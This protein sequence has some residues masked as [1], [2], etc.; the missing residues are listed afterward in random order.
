MEPSTSS[1]LRCRLSLSF[2]FSVLR[3]RSSFNLGTTML[4]GVGY[5]VLR[6][7]S[8]A[9]VGRY[10]VFV[11][12]DRVPDLS[13]NTLDDGLLDEAS[14]IEMGDD[15]GA[16]SPSLVFEPARRIRFRAATLD[17]GG[18]VGNE[19]C[20]TIPGV[21]FRGC[22]GL[23]G[24][25]SNIVSNV[26]QY[27]PVASLALTKILLLRFDGH[28]LNGVWSSLGCAVFRNLCREGEV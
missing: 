26:P 14:T 17:D 18:G 20:P 22:C 16:E 6:F 10:G 7:P 9:R 3:T 15:D 2:P 21:R 12:R 13:A 24:V 1:G 11:S 4:S 8:F 5:I 28:G 19:L 23:D 27:S 25:V